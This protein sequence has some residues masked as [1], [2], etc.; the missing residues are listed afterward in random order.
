M[1]SSAARGND[2]AHALALMPQ[3]QPGLQPGLQPQQHGALMMPPPPSTYTSYR[4]AGQV[5]QYGAPD[6][7]AVQQAAQ[8]QQAEANRGAAQYALQAMSRTSQINQQLADLTRQEERA[9]ADQLYELARQDRKRKRAQLETEQRDMLTQAAVN[10]A[11][12][13]A[14]S[15]PAYGGYQASTGVVGAPTFSAYLAPSSSGRV[16]QAW[17]AWPRPG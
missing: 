14:A 5:Q 2:D 13:G 1:H 4:Y 11:M 8:Q 9:R 12:A 16:E 15:V 3:Q 7:Y 10:A 17:P 6:Y